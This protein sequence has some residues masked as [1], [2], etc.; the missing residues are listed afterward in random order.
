[1]SDSS[2]KV[3]CVE[4]DE[5]DRMIIK[6]AVK[7]SGMNI[8]LTFAEDIDSGKS[9]TADTEYDCI[10][11]DYNL[12]GGSGL[13]LLKYIRK[14]NNTSP[15]II[16]T[17][18]GDEKIAV[19]AMKNGASDYIPK[20]LLSAE[21]L[22]QSLRF[23]LKMRETER[24]KLRI[25]REL[26][27]IQ[28]RLATVVSNSPIIL[29]LLDEKGNFTLFEGKGLHDT[30][31][32]AM[33]PIGQPI[34]SIASVIPISRNDFNDTMNGREKTSVCQIGEKYYEVFYSPM[35][36]ESNEVSGVIGVASDI[37]IHKLAEEELTNAKQYAEDVAKMKEQFLANMSHEIRTPMNGIMGLTRILLGTSVNDEQFRYLRSIKTCSDNLLVIINDI[38]DLSK[39]EAGK[40]NFENVAFNLADIINHTFELF[41][42]KAK[43]KNLL[44]NYEIDSSVPIAIMG[45]PTR[46]SQIT[47]NLV[48]NAL[49]FTNAGG[50]NVHIKMRSEREDNLTIDFEVADSGIG[51]AET[52]LSSIFESFTQASNDTTRKFGGTGLGLTIVKKLIELQG[53]SIGVRSTVGKGTTFFFHITFGRASEAEIE[54]A[55][56]DMESDTDI[57]YLNI[58]VAEDNAINQMIV[59]KVFSDWGVSIVIA[60][61]G[62]QCV[63][64]LQSRNFDLVLMDIQMPEMDGNAAT[65]K[66]R[67]E[68]PEPLRS[69]PIM[70]MTAHATESEKKKCFDSGMNDYVSKPFNPQE[71]KKK[72]IALTGSVKAPE[73]KPIPVKSEVIITE[74]TRKPDPVPSSEV[75]SQTSE[76]KIDLSYLKQIG[77]DNPAFIM[78]MIEMFLQKTPIA[79]EEMNEKFK[80]QN[81]NDLKDIAHRIK[82]SY[83]Y[84]GLKQI[85]LMLAEI[86]NNSITKTNLDSIPQLMSNVESQTQA[87]FKVLE[88]EL[89]K[90]K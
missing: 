7:S 39:I 85:H 74:K 40:M 67:N 29:F 34:E 70:A 63:Q 19:E 78:Q 33:R 38:L 68:L 37:T 62:A 43:E 4:D 58:L 88:E 10:F 53:G 55:T 66:I 27:D 90:L 52:S 64:Q 26:L 36:N 73:V 46:L 5:L 87:A 57:S 79:L 31:I 17:S 51:I 60:E 45:D 69:I 15:V 65:R 12:P 77:G 49:K 21:G 6:R 42:P 44:L 82:P 86:E 8:D 83:T 41:E 75:T 11:L 20:N 14:N 72:V 3:L 16:V 56:R 1:M 13:E 71:L 54:R 50:V 18:Q 25:E 84:V 59:K 61:N 80:A 35:R 30:G 24:E 9:K 47:N 2:I 81:W 76:I 32:D 23:V 22:A 89:L 28:Q 48:S